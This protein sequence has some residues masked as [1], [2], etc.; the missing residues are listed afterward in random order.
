MVQGLGI[1]V[2]VGELLHGSVGMGITVAEG[3]ADELALLAEE[4][5][6]APPGVYADAL[7]AYLRL[8][9]LA[10]GLDDFIIQIGEVP[11]D[12]A[13]HG[14]LGILETCP[15]LHIDLFSVIRGQ[16]GT[17]ARGPQVNC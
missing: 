17:S 12:V 14:D 4:G 7:Q 10:Q 11:I 9:G 15:H 13:C 2:N 1:H 6:V 8:C 3:L 5:K 16:Y